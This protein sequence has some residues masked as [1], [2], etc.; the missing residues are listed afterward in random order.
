MPKKEGYYIETNCLQWLNSKIAY[1][2]S[3]IR[4]AWQTIRCE[5][6]VALQNGEDYTLDRAIKHRDLNR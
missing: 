5:Y 3:S 2:N 1:E 6:F 4:V